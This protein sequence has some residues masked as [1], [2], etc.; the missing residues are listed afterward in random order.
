MGRPPPGFRGGPINPDRWFPH[1]CLASNALGLVADRY[2]GLEYGFFHEL[3]EMGAS[4][5]IRIRNKPLMEVVAELAL[6][7]ADRAAGVTW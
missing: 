2:Y 5:V 6:S 1:P 7:K 4:Y 3:S